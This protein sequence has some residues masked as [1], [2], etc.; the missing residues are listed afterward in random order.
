MI[1][2]LAWAAQT[3]YNILGA[4]VSIE[5]CFPQ[6]W[7]LEVQDQGSLHGSV[8]CGLSSWFVTGHLL[9]VL[10]HGEETENE[11]GGEREG[12]REREEGA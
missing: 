12:E 6:C 1:S 7:N 4:W 3:R 2:D 5:I 11:R 9:P 10:S 8:W